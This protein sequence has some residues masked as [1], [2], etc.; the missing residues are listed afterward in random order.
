MVQLNVFEIKII[1]SE[2]IDIIARES[3]YFF[4]TVVS[5][6]SEGRD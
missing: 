2:S 3:I 1:L 5:A 6:T 4:L